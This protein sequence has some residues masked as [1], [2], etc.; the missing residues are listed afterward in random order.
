MIE[1]GLVAALT[2]LAP[3]YPGHLPQGVA[4]PALSYSRLTTERSSSHDGPTGH[5]AATMAI[6]AHGDTHAAAMVLG[7]QVARLL[8]GFTGTLG[9]VTIGYCEITNET[10]LDW[11]D[12]A[13][14]WLYVVEATLY[15]EET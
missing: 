7:R 12:A 1:E 15:Y 11:A 2:A 6:A 8:D 5:V 13:D 10:D 9:T 3:V 14:A 4:R